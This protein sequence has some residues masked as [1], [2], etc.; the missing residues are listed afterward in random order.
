MP[1]TGY[2]Y[3]NTGIST[4]IFSISSNVSYS[5]TNGFTYNQGTSKNIAPSFNQSVEVAPYTKIDVVA[6]VRNYQII[7]NYRIKVEGTKSG[8]QFVIYGIWKGI[9]CVVVNYTV[10]QS[11][12]KTGEII[13][14]YSSKALQNEKINSIQDDS[15]VNSLAP[16]IYRNYF[17]TF[18]SLEYQQ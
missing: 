17:L 8:R 18:L 2:L 13:N 7:C 16:F 10:N 15:L 1:L 12:T 11:S 9:S 5:V 6:V 14:T 3:G 4:P